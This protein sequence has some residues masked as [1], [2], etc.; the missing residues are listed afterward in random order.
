MVKT[1]NTKFSSASVAK[2]SVVLSRTVDKNFALE[3]EVSRLRHHESILWKRLHRT[4]REKEIVKSIIRQIGGR[5][6]KEPL[7]D[8]VAEGVEITDATEEVADKREEVKSAGEEVA[9]DEG[10]CHESD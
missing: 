10:M 5:A 7:R 8:V 4:T 3:A 6:R 9:E 1:K 2:W